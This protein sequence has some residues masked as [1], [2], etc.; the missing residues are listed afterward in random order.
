MEN[1]VI[2]YDGVCGLCDRLVRFVLRHDQRGIFRFAPL[3][4]HFAAEALARHN[5]DATQLDAMCVITGGESQPEK[6]LCKSDAAIFILRRLSWP[7]KA[8]AQSRIFPRPLR[9]WAYDQIARRRYRI[10]GKLERCPVP[11]ASVRARFI[12]L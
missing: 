10:F 5:K 2:L 6:L 1:P 7:W 11:D 4:S 3:Q 9:D 12:D 8:L